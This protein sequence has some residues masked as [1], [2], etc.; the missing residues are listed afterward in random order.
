MTPV[1]EFGTSE[2]TEC[3]FLFV[4]L[5]HFHEAFLQSSLFDVLL[6]DT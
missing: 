3:H 2:V 4:F 6:S 5:L 1:N